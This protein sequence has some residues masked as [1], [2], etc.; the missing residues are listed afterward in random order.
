MPNYKH[1]ISYH[2]LPGVPMRQFREG[3]PIFYAFECAVLERKMSSGLVYT[4]VNLVNGKKMRL[5]RRMDYPLESELEGIT[6]LIRCSGA[7]G[8]GRY[9]VER[10]ACTIIYKSRATEILRDTYDVFMP[11]Y[12]YKV[13]IGQ[14]ETAEHFLDVIAKHQVTVAGTDKCALADILIPAIF[15]KRGRLNDIHNVSV[16]PALPIIEVS[17]MPIVISVSDSGQQKEA[18]DAVNK[19]SN[20]LVEYG[21][22]TTPVSCALNY[23]GVQPEAAD[24]HICSNRL[25]LG[26]AA[27]RASGGK[28]V[29]PDYQTLIV[30]GAESLVPVARKKYSTALSSKTAEPFCDKIINLAFRRAKLAGQAQKLTQKLRS[31]NTRLFIGLSSSVEFLCG[32]GSAYYSFDKIDADSI[33]HIGNIKSIANDL[34]AT[35]TGEALFAKAEELLAWACNKYNADVRAINLNRL[36]AVVAGDD[37][38]QRQQVMS[39]HHAI[40]DLPEIQYRLESETDRKKNESPC[41]NTERGASG[42]TESKMLEAI[43]DLTRLLL[44]PDTPFGTRSEQVL[45]LIWEAKRIR[46]QSAAILRH[47]ELSYWFETSPG[48]DSL[49]AAPADI[50]KRLYT[51]LWAKKVPAVLVFSKQPEGEALEKY[52]K[53]LGLDKLGYIYAPGK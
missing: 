45:Q 29:L 48:G 18:V 44:Q 6:E 37:K 51:D 4:A 3:Y 27:R 39:I 15:A 35:L 16:N 20:M 38:T 13:R 26:D 14:L 32:S 36:L 10:P 40:C 11:E 47:G 5:C 2:P 52:R 19:L 12:R 9:E 23:I 30:L 50:G 49:C 22:I 1:E 17:R 25:L 43:W 33:R 8:K 21:V 24:V 7:A 53:L 42:R 41:Y 28:P 46:D 31:E 34:I